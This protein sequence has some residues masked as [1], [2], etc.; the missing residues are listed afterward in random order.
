MDLKIKSQRWKSKVIIKIISD[1]PSEL[2]LFFNE[3]TS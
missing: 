2:K 1:F 3:Y